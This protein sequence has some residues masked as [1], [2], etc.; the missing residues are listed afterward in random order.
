[1][2]MIR[3]RLNQYPARTIHVG[4]NYVSVMAPM[5]I[6]TDTQAGSTLGKRR[7]YGKCVLRL[8]R[9]V[10]GRYAA[11]RPGNLFD[12]A[13]WKTLES[14]DLPFVP[15]VWGRACELYSGD[16]E[17]SLPSGQDADSTIWII[18]DRPM[19]FRLVAIMADV[20]FGEN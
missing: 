14:Y 10:G 11:S 20:D 12:V 2:I 7:A 4:L 3:Q 8:Y 9:S 18:Q 19:P 16:R 17:L 15:A 1:M 6:E 5:P 13:A